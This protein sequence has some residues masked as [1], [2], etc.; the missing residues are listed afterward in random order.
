MAA[1]SRERSERPVFENDFRT[2]AVSRLPP[3]AATLL[4]GAP[5]RVASFAEIE[6]LETDE[7]GFFIASEIDEK[8]IRWASR[9]QTWL[10][11]QS[12][13]ARQQDAARDL[14]MQLIEVM[15]S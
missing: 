5:E 12:G 6:L 2:L 7:P 1:T 8:R 9:F 15:R 10:E 14:R 11:L 13:D 4:E 3:L